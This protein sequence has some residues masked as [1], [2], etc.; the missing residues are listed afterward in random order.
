MEL[1]FRKITTNYPYDLLLLADETIEGINKYLF[2]SDVYIAQLS[3]QEQTVGVFCLCR[4]DADTIEI[5][6]IAVS[7]KL[8]GNGIGSILIDKAITIAAEEGYKQIIVGTADCGIKQIRFYEKNGFVKYDIRKNY[9]TE[10][11]DNPIY[12]NGVQ[13]KD[14]VMLKR[15]I[16]NRMAQPRKLVPTENKGKWGYLDA[17]TGEEVVPF[18]YDYAHIFSVGLALVQLNGWWGYVDK[19]GKEVIPCIYNP[20]YSFTKTGLAAVAIDGKHGFIDQTGKVVIPLIYDDARY[21][22]KDGKAKVKLNGETFFI[23]MEGNR[24]G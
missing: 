18:V 22:N 3:E 2:K 13:L 9:Y 14:M 16:R 20:A 24:V 12:E 4:I 1:I 23:D 21:F 7:E 15:K 17:V 19:T 8:Q 11:Y 5:M 6:N 10:I